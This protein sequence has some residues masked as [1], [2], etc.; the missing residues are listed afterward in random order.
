VVK[1]ISEYKGYFM[2]CLQEPA[3]GRSA[4][5]NTKK[6]LHQGLPASESDA[7]LRSHVKEYVQSL[8]IISSAASQTLP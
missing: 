2:F 1:D 5:H 8:E 6:Y 4:T 7:N 3:Q